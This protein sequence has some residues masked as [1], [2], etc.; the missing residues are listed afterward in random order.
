MSDGPPS[1][2][3]YNPSLA[4]AAI[5]AALFGLSAVLHAIQLLRNRTWYFVPFLIGA[6]CSFPLSG[7]SMFNHLIRVVQLRRWATE[8]AVSMRARLQT[9]Q[10]CR[11]L[12]RLSSP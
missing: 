9:G 3:E 12:S 5:F 4:A 11:S 10:R 2:Y 7:V 8:H 1:K 6:V